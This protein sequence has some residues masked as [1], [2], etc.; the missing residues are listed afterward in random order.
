MTCRSCLDGPDIQWLIDWMVGVRNEDP[1]L[2]AVLMVI[3]AIVLVGFF[4]RAIWLAVVTK[5]KE[6]SNVS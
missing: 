1:L 6:E 2:W 4:G 3:S 5:G